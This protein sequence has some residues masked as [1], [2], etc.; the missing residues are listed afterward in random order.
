MA[1]PLEVADPG[2]G[3]ESAPISSQDRHPTTPSHVA[4]IFHAFPHGSSSR[5]PRLPRIF[6]AF[7]IH[8]L[9]F[10]VIPLFVHG[11]VLLIND[12]QDILS[13]RARSRFSTTSYA[14][15]ISGIVLVAVWH[16]V[17]GWLYWKRDANLLAAQEEI[18]NAE[19][20][21]RGKENAKLA[22]KERSLLWMLR[23]WSVPLYLGA[24]IVLWGLRVALRLGKPVLMVGKGNAEEMGTR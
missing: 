15:I 1:T 21:V 20:E 12:T 23:R 6:V 10:S 17:L 7:V 3:S 19:V 5:L 4:P 9:A 18:G 8:M 13:R 16:A 14:T 22:S 11:A 2:P 24:M